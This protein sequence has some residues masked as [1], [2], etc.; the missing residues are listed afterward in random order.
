VRDPEGA[1]EIPSG[2]AVDDRQLDAVQPGDPVHH[3]VHGPV[4]ADRDQQ[5]G[6]SRGRLARQFRQVLR[7]LREE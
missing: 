2:A 1:D 5:A 7:A 3:L 6:A 4:P